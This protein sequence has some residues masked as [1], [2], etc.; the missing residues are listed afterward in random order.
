MN[1]IEAL[2]P[3]T[4]VFQLFGLSVARFSTCKK[5]PLRGAI[6]HYPLLLIAIRCGV[7]FF[8]SMKYQ[9]TTDDDELIAAINIIIIISAHL[10]EI[11]ILIESFVKAS[12]EQTFMDNLLE[13]DNILI[14]HFDIDLKSNKLRK[15]TFKRL[16]IWIGV[17]GIEAS[18]HL[19]MHCT[20][21]YFPHE[22]ICTLSLFTASLAYFQI[23]TWANLIRYRLRIVTRV[24]NDLN[25]DHNEKTKRGRVRETSHRPNGSDWQR[26]R[27]N[28]IGNANESN[29]AINDTHN[30]D[31]LRVL[32]DLY[33]R[34]WV[35]TNLLHERF[36]F[37]MVL[38]IGIDFGYLILQLYFIFICIRK[39]ETCHFFPADLSL[40]IL[41]IVRLSMLSRAGQRVADE[42]LRIAHAIHRN[43]NM[44]GSLKMSSFVS[45]IFDKIIRLFRKNKIV[46]VSSDSRIFISIASPKNATQRVWFF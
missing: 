46:F 33:N 31:Q 9:L 19:L 18:Y 16:L 23:I 1:T 44:K 41:N 13:I 4:N 17:T 12:R 42:A 27:S 43:K 8:V 35:Q 45:E 34:L 6:K 24:T 22:L 38:N 29:S 21:H 25:C 7:F 28:R 2:Q 10:L 30:F 11:S 5:S 39:F 3:V 36:K 32:C 14:Q 15:S 37:T 26:S 40:C 20:A